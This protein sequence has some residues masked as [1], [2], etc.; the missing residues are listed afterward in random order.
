LIEQCII[1]QFIEGEFSCGNNPYAG[2]VRLGFHDCATFDSTNKSFPGGC[3]A[4]GSIHCTEFNKCEFTSVDN[5]G[6]QPWIL[7][8]DNMYDGLLIN[9]KKLSDIL[10]RADFWHLAFNRAVQLSSNFSIQPT[11]WAGRYDP[12]QLFRN[13]S[14]FGPRFPGRIPQFFAFSE[15]ERVCGRNGMDNFHASA[16]LGGH[17]LGQA[18]PT[19]SGFRGSWDPT[20][21][22]FDNLYWEVLQNDDWFITN[23]EAVNEFTGEATNMTQYSLSGVNEKVSLQLFVDVNQLVDT[24]FPRT[25][26]PHVKVFQPEPACEVRQP[27]FTEPAP[28]SVVLEAWAK[29]PVTFFTAFEGAWELLSQWGCDQTTNPPQC[30]DVAEWTSELP[31]GTN[32]Y[33]HR[34]KPIHK[35]GV[36]SWS[37]PVGEQSPSVTGM[38]DLNASEEAY[39]DKNNVPPAP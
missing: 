31:C 39:N 22:V 11:Y 26:C 23:V 24:T 8:I 28:S 14:S 10:S 33:R 27:I 9:D 32:L 3:N 18:H 19:I 38:E 6:L 13:P 17:S 16:L 34:C 1:D 25:E 15:M 30:P 21:A 12:Q 7:G 4:W 37:F 2:L 5:E 29:E 20:P 36:H 35:T